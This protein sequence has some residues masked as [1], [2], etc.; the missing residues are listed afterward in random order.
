MALAPML[1]PVF[2]GWVMTWFSWRW[3]FVIQAVVAMVACIGVFRM[4]E[5]LKTPSATG[6]LQTAGIYLQLLRNWR[7]VG[8]ALIMSLTALDWTDKIRTIGVL[9]TATGSIILSVVPDQRR[10]QFQPHDPP[11]GAYFSAS[12]S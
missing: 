5:T 9:E 6:I 8:D 1:A 12:R 11:T 2:G 10:Y 7:Y 4:S 3:I